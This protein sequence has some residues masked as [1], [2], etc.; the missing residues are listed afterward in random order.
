[1]PRLAAFLLLILLATAAMAQPATRFGGDVRLRGYDLADVWSFDDSSEFDQWT[2]IRF[3]TRLFADVSIDDRTQVYIRLANQHYGEGVSDAVDNQSNK[4]FVDQAWLDLAEFAGLPVDLRLGRQAA[5]YGD[6]FVLFDG[7]S[8]MASTSVYLDGARAVWHA[9]PRLDVDAFGYLDQENARDN[10]SDDDI[11]LMGVYM[12]GRGLA[13]EAS[14]QELYGVRRVDQVLDRDILMAGARVKGDLAERLTYRFEGALQRGDI[15][16]DGEQ[17]AHAL[18][19]QLD[20]RLPL[21]TVFGRHV[22][23]SG[24]DPD[25]EANER[26]DVMYGG[27][28]Q[29]GDLLAWKYVNVGPHNALWQV[30]MNYNENSSTGGEAVYSNLVMTTLGA[31]WQPNSVIKAEASW[32]LLRFHEVAG[33]DDFGDYWQVSLKYQY[34]P[35]VSF[36]AYGAMIDPGEAFGDD[37]DPATEVYLETM[38]RF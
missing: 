12:R 8:Q 20:V 27:W 37:A 7:Q 16:R 29:F 31:R 9:A 21:V 17:E 38:V 23:M 1:M 13:G 10:G 19:A 36:A 35:A 24:D 6:G 4:V 18:R 25:T 15:G 28:P 26:W 14:E 34:S 32:S 33:D 5:M 11:Y 3:R 22:R 30:D 2:V